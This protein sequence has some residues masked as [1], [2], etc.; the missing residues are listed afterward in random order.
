MGVV[1]EL[2]TSYSR[3]TR[4]FPLSTQLQA[5]FVLELT[6][7]WGVQVPTNLA[8]LLRSAEEHNT[9]IRTY[10][11]PTDKSYTNQSL[12]QWA[13]NLGKALHILRLWHQVLESWKRVAMVM[14]H[15]HARMPDEFHHFRACAKYFR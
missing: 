5:S 1:L 4:P 8:M 14:K 10:S 12:D 11:D 9:K 15:S 2:L 3:E 6:N 13:D 7:F